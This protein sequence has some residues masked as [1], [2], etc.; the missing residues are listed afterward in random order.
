M[1]IK[2]RSH[3]LN[4]Y[5]ILW[6]FFL[7]FNVTLGFSFFTSL[8]LISHFVF[9]LCFFFFGKFN[10][11]WRLLCEVYFVEFL[12]LWTFPFLYATLRKWFWIVNTEEIFIHAIMK[13]KEELFFREE[14]KESRFY[15][16]KSFSFRF[17]ALNL[18]S[19]KV[20]FYNPVDSNHSNIF[21][22]FIFICSTPTQ[23]FDCTQ[24][25]VLH[26]WK[27]GKHERGWWKKIK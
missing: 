8:F 10:S 16:T 17:I 26:S 15:I 19:K 27:L 2:S 6:K 14:E 18:Q 4:S 22:L 5:F 21:F 7:K 25:W 13:H 1:K 11:C 3:P 20:P 9:F 23:W 12:M 24:V